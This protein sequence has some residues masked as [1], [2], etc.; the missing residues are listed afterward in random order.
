MSDNGKI[1]I[2][3]SEENPNPWIRQV[4]Q[5]TG[6]LIQVDED[7]TRH[8][9]TKGQEEAQGSEPYVAR[10]RSAPEAGSQGR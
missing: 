10:D 3:D 5:K 7:G 6:H 4:I 2:V 8:Y 1:V 9:S